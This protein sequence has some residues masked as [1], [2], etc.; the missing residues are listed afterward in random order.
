[1][2]KGPS[3]IRWE[4]DLHMDALLHGLL[5]SLLGAACGTQGQTKH[6]LPGASWPYTASNGLSSDV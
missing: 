2:F 3:L 6:T 5:D 1:M 4:E